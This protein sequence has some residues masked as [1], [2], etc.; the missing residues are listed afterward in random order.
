MHRVRPTCGPTRR[1]LGHNFANHETV[2]HSQD[3]FA[4]GDVHTNT[5]EGFFSILKR[6]VYCTYQRVSEEHLSRY[7]AEFD[8]RYSTRAKLGVDDSTRTGLAVKGRQGQAADLRNSY[9]V[10]GSCPSPLP[11]C[12]ASWT[13]G[14]EVRDILASCQ[15]KPPQNGSPS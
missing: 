10:A 3:E 6:G 1:G 11:S 7:L 15:R 8:F 4:R 9:G 2:N 14:I 5:V 12:G 13:T